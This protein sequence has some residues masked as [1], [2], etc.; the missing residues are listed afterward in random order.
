MKTAYLL[1][2]W[3]LDWSRRLNFDETCLALSPAGPHGWWWKA[4]DEKAGFQRPSK[5]AVSV[6][7]VTS[8][9][10]AKVAAQIFLRGGAEKDISQTSTEVWMSCSHNHWV[11]TETLRR[12]PNPCNTTDQIAIRRTHRALPNDK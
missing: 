1:D 5:Q 8:A 7:L 2:K 10:K 12:I 9:A 11:F 4:K 3:W 6:T